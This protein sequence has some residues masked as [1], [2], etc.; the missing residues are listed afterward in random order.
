MP[1]LRKDCGIYITE[2]IYN[3]ITYFIFS[4]ISMTRSK[5]RYFKR[6]PF[7]YIKYQPQLFYTPNPLKNFFEILNL[8]RIS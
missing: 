7:L 4:I 1:K 8:E 6:L 3:T 2:K 5:E